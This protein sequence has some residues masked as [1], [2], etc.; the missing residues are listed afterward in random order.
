MCRYPKQHQTLTRRMLRAVVL[1]SR[2]HEI[3]KCMLV[4]TSLASWV[5]DWSILPIET[6]LWEVLPGRGKYVKHWPVRGNKRVGDHC[7]S[8]YLP[9]TYCRYERLFGTR[10]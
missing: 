9:N 3:T 8:G 7:L 4:V 10:V 5:C 2:G 1:N 6:L